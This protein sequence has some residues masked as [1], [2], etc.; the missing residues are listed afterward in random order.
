MSV[1]CKPPLRFAEDGLNGERIQALLAE[2]LDDMRAQS[3]P[4]STHA[5]DLDG[6]RQP[7]LRFWTAWRGQTLLACG[8]LKRLGADHAEIKSMRTPR[9][10][11][12]LGAGKAMLAHLIDQA[13]TLGYSRLSLETGSMASFAPA[14][15]LYRSFGF[16]ECGP[17]A[18]YRE[19]PNSVFM[20]LAL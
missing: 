1:N 11:R 5:L 17:F 14:Q 4:E 6:L 20:T 10:L 8:A 19:D 18:N 9:A 2:H 15:Q 3:P 16:V 13:R 7:G 12:G